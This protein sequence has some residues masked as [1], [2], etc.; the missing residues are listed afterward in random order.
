LEEF[1]KKAVGLF[2]YA[3][4]YAQAAVTLEKNKPGATH[5]DAPVYFLY[6]HAIELYLKSF[7]V[8]EGHDLEYLR[9]K[10]GHKVKP[11]VNLC[12][13]AGVQFS[14]DGQQAINLMASTDNV[15]SSRY[16]RI[17]THQRLPFQVY[18]ELCQTLHEQI[19]WKVYEGSGV[20]R[21]P[22]LKAL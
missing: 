1:Q 3:H 16:I 13:N 10:Y 7:L 9:K 14:L 20:T 21:L 2:N 15:M 17:G 6:F 11:L 12:M 4:S 8:R 19:G 22:V 18:I 5:D